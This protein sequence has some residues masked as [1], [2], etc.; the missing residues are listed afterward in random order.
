MLIRIDKCISAC[1]TCLLVVLL[2]ALCAANGYAQTLNAQLNTA[3][4]DA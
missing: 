3:A 4:H 2:V 1:G